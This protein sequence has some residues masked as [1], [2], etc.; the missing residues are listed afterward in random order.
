MCIR[1]RYGL[2]EFINEHPVA[3][4]AVVIKQSQAADGLVEG[5]EVTSVQQKTLSSDKSLTRNLEC[6]R[7]CRITRICR[8]C[9]LFKRHKNFVLDNVPAVCGTDG[10]FSGTFARFLGARV[11]EETVQMLT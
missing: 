9:V 6:R 4:T 5:G 7:L 1:D 10:L 3:P 2:K 11:T 8:A